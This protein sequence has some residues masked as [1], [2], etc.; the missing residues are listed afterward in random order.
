MPD[1][2]EQDLVLRAQGGDVDAIG[3]LY[4]LHHKGIFRYVWLRVGDRHVAE[5]LMGDVF[6]RML[7]G[8]PDYRTKGVPFRAWLYRIAHNLLVD[9]YRKEGSRVSLPLDQA[10]AQSANGNDP[11]PIVERMLTLARL[12]RALLELDELQQ[13]VV[14]LRFLGGLSLREVALALDKTV[15]AVK[16]HQHRGLAALRVALVQE[17][18]KVR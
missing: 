14:A 12:H 16:A 5:D 10:E 11:G 2:S 13:E 4:D 3:E 9:Y 6:I 7:G 1:F 18:E 15:A 8:L 17:E